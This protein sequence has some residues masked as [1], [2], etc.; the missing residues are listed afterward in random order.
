MSRVK[1]LTTWFPRS[2]V[3]HELTTRFHSSFLAST[4]MQINQSSIWTEP[5]PR[6]WFS[7]LSNKLLELKFIGSKVDTS[8]LSFW[9]KSITIFILIYIDG[10]VD[11][12]RVLIASFSTPT[13]FHGVHGSNL[14]S[15]GR[16]PNQN[17][18]LLLK[19]L[20][21]SFG[22]KLSCVTLAF[23]V[24]L[25]RKLC[26]D[27]IIATYLSAN[28]V[29]QARTKHVE[30]NFHFVRDHEP[31]K[32]IQIHFIPSKDQLTNKILGI[33]SQAQH[34]ITLLIIRGPGGGGV[35]KHKISHPQ[36]QTSIST[37]IMILQD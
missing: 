37:V 18:K 2:R 22:S 21:N 29:F 6:A 19:L 36:I 4:H 31:N 15:S 17:T 12:P 3:L 9:S 34:T 1:C 24:H 35:L 32:S 26:C 14:L 25:H 5:T 27:Y 8:L 30:I 23:S 20:P 33:L 16:A 13:L 11:D 7:Y 10:L 28:P